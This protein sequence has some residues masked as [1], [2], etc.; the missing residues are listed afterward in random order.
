M[1]DAVADGDEDQAAGLF[2]AI[3]IQQGAGTG[4]TGDG[5]A[6]AGAG[7][8]ADAFGEGARS[9]VADGAVLFEDFIGHAGE[10]FLEVR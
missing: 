9:L 6:D 5:E 7:L 8:F 3:S 2:D 10:F 4:D 1:A